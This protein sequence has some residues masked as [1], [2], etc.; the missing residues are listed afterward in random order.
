MSRKKHSRRGTT[1]VEMALVIPII[2][3]LLF[4]AIDFSRAQNVRNT[5]ALAAYE[6]ARE[7]ILPGR[8]ASGIQQVV[9]ANIDTLGIVDAVITVTPTTITPRTSEI[10]VV[11]TTPMDSN[12]Y[13]YSKFFAGKTITTTCTLARESE[14][15]KQSQDATLTQ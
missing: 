14:L 2:F 11:V 13:A 6:G 5:A 7:G 8:T 15:T 3:G 1:A 9:Q 12:L 10:T 4:A